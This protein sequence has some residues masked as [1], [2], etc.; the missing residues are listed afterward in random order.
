MAAAVIRKGKMFSTMASNEIAEENSD[1]VVAADPG[2]CGGSYDD[3][4]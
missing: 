2:E 1:C 3:P 4:S